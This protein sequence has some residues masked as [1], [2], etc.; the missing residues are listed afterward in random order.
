MRLALSTF[1]N[2]ISIVFDSADQFLIIE[3]NGLNIT[4]RLP[5]KFVTADPAGR[6][7]QLKDQNIDVLIC[8][9]IS[10]LM[11]DSIVAKG[12]T[13]HPFVKGEVNDVVAAYQNNQLGQSAFLLPGC[14]RRTRGAGFGVQRNMRCRWRQPS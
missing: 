7:K 8:G 14:R 10:R 4:K 2:C 5:L 9:A 6:T 11:H 3:T 1:K 13:V 12:I